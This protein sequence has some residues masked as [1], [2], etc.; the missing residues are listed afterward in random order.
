M[1]YRSVDGVGSYY[2]IIQNQLRDH[3]GVFG[4]LCIDPETGLI[5]LTVTRIPGLF[6]WTGTEA[7]CPLGSQFRGWSVM[8]IIG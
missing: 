6:Y 8:L 5:P 4:M 3:R 7:V 1:T 2:V